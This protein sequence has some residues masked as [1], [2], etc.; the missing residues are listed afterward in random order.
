MNTTLFFGDGAAW[1]WGVLFALHVLSWIY[2]WLIDWLHQKEWM[3]NWTWLTVVLGVGYTLAGAAVAMWNAEMP[4]NMAVL[5]VV[6]TF[7]ATGIPMS[8]GDIQR[9]LRWKANGGDA[10]SDLALQEGKAEDDETTTG[11]NPNG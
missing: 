6:L 7:V 2:N 11:D 9:V 10:V 8:V 4:A 3:D 1:Y 5:G